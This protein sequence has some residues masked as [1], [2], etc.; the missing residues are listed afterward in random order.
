MKRCMTL[1]LLAFTLLA[2]GSQKLLAIPAGATVIILG[3]SLSYGTGAAKGE[4]YPALLAKRTDWHI[5]NA[6]VPGDSTAQG[7][8]RLP[9][10]LETHRPLL[11]IVVLGGNDFLGNIDIAETEANLRSMIQSTKLNNVQTLLVAIPDY[12]P[13]KAALAGL[14]DHPLYAKLAAETNVPL[15][16][17]VFSVVLSNSALKADH[18]HPNAQGYQ[19]IE[20]KLQAK[21]TALGLYK[22]Q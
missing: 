3:D 1:C 13:V 20:A 9:H 14:R 4:D 22:P 2:C 11:L 10:L 16:D 21:L 17:K 15:A 12:Q 5:I 18:V 19:L 7:L 8:A 6:S